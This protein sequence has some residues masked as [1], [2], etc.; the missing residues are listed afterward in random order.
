M[1]ASYLTGTDLPPAGVARAQALVQNLVRSTSMERLQL[2]QLQQVCKQGNIPSAPIRSLQ[3]VEFF[4][5]T[6]KLQLAKPCAGIQANLQLFW[7]SNFFSLLGI[8]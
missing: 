6:W 7:S 4:N 5:G 2:L 8:F 1:L 3:V